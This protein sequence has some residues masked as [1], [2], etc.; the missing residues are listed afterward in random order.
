MLTTDAS[1]NCD[2]LSYKDGHVTMLVS[3]QGTE[4][5]SGLYTDTVI[6]DFETDGELD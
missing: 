5:S 3:T 1:E 6:L 4:V 2:A